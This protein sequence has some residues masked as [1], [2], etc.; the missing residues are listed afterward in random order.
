VERV[1]YFA[2]ELVEYSASRLCRNL[3]LSTELGDIEGAGGPRMGLGA[4]WSLWQLGATTVGHTVFGGWLGSRQE[5][6]EVRCSCAFEQPPSIDLAVL[7]VLRGQLD[8]CGPE[9]LRDTC[10]E[11]RCPECFPH[12]GLLV[13]LVAGF[14]AGVAVVLILDCVTRRRG[15]FIRDEEDES[16]NVV[17]PNTPLGL[18]RLRNGNSH[19]G[20]L[21]PAGGN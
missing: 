3:Q 2:A 7:D 16:A 21:A 19:A 12:N 1:N 8:R 13:G 5:P 20:Y 17:R 14:A 11:V 18:R 15:R 10:P 9:R 6:R 4:L